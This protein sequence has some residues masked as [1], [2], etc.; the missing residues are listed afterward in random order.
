V[1]DAKVGACW[2]RCDAETQLA[3]LAHGRPHLGP[4][5]D[6]PAHGGLRQKMFNAY[7]ETIHVPLVVSNPVLFRGA[8]DAA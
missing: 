4:R 3:A 7:E 6:G 8:G 2:R 5:R 1:V